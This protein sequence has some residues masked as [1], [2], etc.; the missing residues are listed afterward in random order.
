MGT[1]FLAGHSLVLVLSSSS[2]QHTLQK[3]SLH[4]PT[5][6]W[7]PDVEMLPQ[8]PLLSHSCCFLCFLPP[9]PPPPTMALGMEPLLMLNKCPT[10][11]LHLSPSSVLSSCGVK[12]SGHWPQGPF[13]PLLLLFSRGSISIRLANFHQ[14]PPPLLCPLSIFPSC[15]PEFTYPY[16]GI[17]ISN[18]CF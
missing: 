1:L 7:S 17:S 8:I 10:T 2:L 13:P 14:S 16:P 12:A 6:R 5:S 18:A 15:C 3:C 11:E 4:I 9:L